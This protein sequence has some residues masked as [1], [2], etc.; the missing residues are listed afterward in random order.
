MKRGTSMDFYI[1]L[2][3]VYME[4][5][6]DVG[7][8]HKDSIPAKSKCKWTVL[9]T[10]RFGITQMFNLLRSYYK[11]QTIKVVYK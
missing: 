6:G 3:A 10:S 8:C 9:V 7:M 2:L 11:I 1:F 4:L 5:K